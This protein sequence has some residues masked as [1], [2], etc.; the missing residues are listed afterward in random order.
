MNR[1]LEESIV[2]ISSVDERKKNVIGTGF[3]FYREKNY[4]YLL[5]C[6]HVVQDVGGQ[7]NILVNNI[8]AKIVAI[9]DTR[10]FDLAVLRVEGLLELPLLQLTSLSEAENINFQIAGYYLYG[11]EKKYIQETVY[12]TLD[13]KVLATQIVENY[14]ENIT[15]WKLL[16]NQN[17]RLRKGYSG[18]PVVD[19]KTG[20]VLGIAT[21]M[22]AEGT[23]GRAISTEALSKIWLEMPPTISLELILTNILFPLQEKYWKILRKAYLNCCPKDWPYSQ[24]QN[25]KEIIDYLLEIPEG[26]NSYSSLIEFVARLLIE[27]EIKNSDYYQQLRIWGNSNYDNLEQ[28]LTDLENVIEKP[29]TSNLQSCLMVYVKPSIQYEDRRYLVSAWFIPDLNEYNY[30]TAEKCYKLDTKKDDFSLAE[31]KEL[32]KDLWDKSDQYVPERNDKQTTIVELFLPRE[33]LTQAIEFWEIEPVEDLEPVGINNQVIIRSSKR[34]EG[35]YTKKRYR[36][37]WNTTWNNLSQ[38][39]HDACSSCLSDKFDDQALI[40][41]L[42]QTLSIED[43]K[44]ID[45]AAIP[46]TIWLRK[47]IED[48]ECINNIF[49]VKVQDLPE[50]VRQQRKIAF[51]QE[52]PEHIGN[53]ISLFW[54]NPYRIPPNINYSMA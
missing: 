30:L 36:N 19:K 9:G 37:T 25:I 22:E 39:F 27:A 8:P 26:R 29:P 4:T 38:R 14:S 28:L 45:K 15:V 11:E 21:N 18:A 52:Q 43:F 31:I 46:I 44:Q 1:Q 50:Q 6:A 47:T 23:V 3:P 35:K 54:E 2:L 17:D 7:E 40:L 5:T 24:P 33:L 12:G 49:Q 20:F 10:G 51:N 41:K 16:I 34:F 32:L 42:T 13:K 53:H 48:V